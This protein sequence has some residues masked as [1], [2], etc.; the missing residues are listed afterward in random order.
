M[1][2]YTHVEEQALTEFL[3]RYGLPPATVFKG[4]AE[5]VENSNFFVQAGAD[6]FILTLYEKRVDPDDLPYFLG[7]M[8][9]VATKGVPSARPIPD[10]NGQILQSLC[11]RPAA[12][13]SF[14][15]GTSPTHPS[16]Q[17]CEEAGKSLAQLHQATADFNKQRA[18]S[19][20]LDG[21][22][23]LIEDIGSDADEIQSGLGQE[24]IDT[25]SMLKNTWPAGL[26]AGTIHADLFPDN[27]LFKSNRIAG[28]IDFY[29]AC[30]DFYA[31]DLAIS[32]NAWTLEG[33][34]DPAHAV[35]LLNG[36]ES[37]RPL[38]AEERNAMPIFLLGA[39]MRFLLTRAYDFLNQVPGSLVRVKDPMPYLQLMRHHRDHPHVFM[40]T[41]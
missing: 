25:Y 24:F 20:G 23:K 6:R 41:N 7:L 15:E 17:Q 5:G 39:A 19:L 36:Y 10:Q 11:G 31:Y 35:A 32:M 26:Q 28:M 27:V 2:V 21:W 37:V 29:F 40:G 14:L 1:A 3:A 4:I 34:T 22:S 33:T 8:D 13:I 18:N 30:T 16:L 9:H 38:S 12:L